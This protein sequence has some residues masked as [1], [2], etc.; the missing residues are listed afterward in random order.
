[1]CI[2]DRLI[3]DSKQYSTRYGK[4]IIISETGSTR[5]MQKYMSGKMRPYGAGQWIEIVNQA[6]RIQMCIRDRLTTL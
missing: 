6:L 5:F 1:M 2:R 3:V 4:P